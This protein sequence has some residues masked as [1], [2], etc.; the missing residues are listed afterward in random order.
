MM[1]R[2]F[3]FLSAGAVAVIFS[4]ASAIVVIAAMAKPTVRPAAK[5][6]V[7]QAQWSF[8]L[9]L[10]CSNEGK[11]IALMECLL[12]Q[13]L[14]ALKEPR[15]D[16]FGCRIF[17]SF[18]VIEKSVTAQG[19]CHERLRSSRG[20]QITSISSGRIGGASLSSSLVNL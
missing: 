12:S 15:C 4:C 13:R 18:H 3:G 6:V 20:C 11:W 19:R 16:H 5:T 10:R 14:D 17:E 7:E 8:A 9:L 2:M 1:T